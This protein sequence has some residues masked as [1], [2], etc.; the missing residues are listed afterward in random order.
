MRDLVRTLCLHGVCV[1]DRRLKL[2][3]NQST[4]DKTTANIL[5][6]APFLSCYN[7]NYSVCPAASLPPLY[8]MEQT[9]T[10]AHSESPY[11]VYDTGNVRQRKN[12]YLKT[13]EEKGLLEIRYM[14]GVSVCVCVQCV[15]VRVW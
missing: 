1:S 2:R 6:P 12:E 14:P 15:F 10:H 3:N 4:P 13:E 7:Y 8:P 5:Y 11:F 9:H